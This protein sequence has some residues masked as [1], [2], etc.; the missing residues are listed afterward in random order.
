[1][2]E[3]LKT[4][5]VLDMYSSIKPE[6]LQEM[7]LLNLKQNKFNYP[8]YC[9]KMATGTGKTWV[10]NALLIWQYL[11][12]RYETEPS[13]LFSKNFLLVAPGLIVYNRLLDAYSGKEQEDGTR[14]F[15]T[16]DF[17]QYESLFIPPAYKDEIYGF[18]Q[19]SV[20][21][22][23]EISKKTTGD[24]LIAITNWHLLAEAEEVEE[25][26]SPLDNLSQIIKGV[27]PLRP[28]VTAGNALDALD[29]QHLRGSEIDFLSN[30]PDLVVFNDE[31]HHIHEIK[32]TGEI[33]EVKWQKSLLKI[34][35]SKN[36]KFIQVDFS[37]TPYSVTGSG[38]KRTQ[39]YFPH[40]IVD[41]DL[42]EAIRKGL[43][44]VI[45]LDRRKEIATLP[46]DFKAERDEENNVVGISEGQRVMLRAGLKKLKILEEEFTKL[47]PNKY[48]K[49]LIL[50]EDTGV[51]RFVTK[52]LIDEG[53]QMDDV[54][55]IH[56][57]RQG[58]VTQ[59]IW[60]RIKQRLFNIDKLSKPKVI[61]SVLMLREGFDVNNICVIVPLRASTSFILLEQTI[62]RGLRLMWRERDYQEIKNESR[63]KL[64]QLKEEPTSYLDILS[65]VEHPAFIE[66]Y[67]DLIRNGFVGELTQDIDSGKSV[68]GDIIKVGLRENYEE[69]D[70]YI[71]QI[72]KAR[73]EDLVSLGL[74]LDT[75]EPYPVPLEQ[76]QQLIPKEGDVF[77][78]Q[79]L[80]VGTSFGEY[81]VTADI[82]NAKS[83]NEFIEKLVKGVSELL[84]PI[85]KKRSKKVFPLMQVN[86]AEIARLVDE[87]IRHKLFNREFS[88]LEN[89]NWRVL[90]LERSGIISHIVKNVSKQIYDMQKNVDITE[91]TVMKRFFSE[92]KELK[93]R[94]NFTVDVS[95]C[96]YEKLAYPSNK[97]GFEKSFIEYLDRDS[98]VNAFIKINENYHDF[99]NI[100]Y[101]REDG[102]LAHYYPDFIVRIGDK[103]YLAETKAQKDV[104]NPNVKQKRLATIDRINKL[105]QL[106]PENRMSATW[107]YALVG[108]STFYA[109]RDK[110][111]NAEELF[112]YLRL[113]KARIEGKLEAF[114]E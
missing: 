1:M 49:M 83:Y 38:Q 84:I 106:K 80:T 99:A 112:N 13:G 63:K 61:I 93:M 82:F 42:P 41:F 109:M 91:A 78:S 69:Y 104:N 25:L 86:T 94:E 70:F 110:G 48:P 76:L 27:L 52:F 24:G 100:T 53:L 67:N 73:E 37:A 71:P 31:A 90:L 57:N 36:E 34:A 50:C 62:G 11:N 66:F 88:P 85:G 6:L 72:I 4:K 7:N 54:I 8:K 20:A 105:N 102:L 39:H 40:I 101:I 107:E 16:S 2:H 14:D 12:A 56:S 111:A 10:M 45:A 64:L 28:G 59:K 98:K 3:F 74:S 113:T 96:I 75:L 103:I 15:G 114:L 19:S 29:N 30:L 9:I 51:V 44:K 60:E 32:K 35:K 108:E 87:Y 89:N 58:E 5:N 21:K 33:S 92:V 65:I 18:L 97:G 68:L 17:K 26:E 95:K 23:E 81:E 77:F 22:K 46:L 43:V 47:G 79:E 55:E